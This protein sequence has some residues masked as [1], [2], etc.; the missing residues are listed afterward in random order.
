M[1]TRME[2]YAKYRAEIRRM[3]PEQFAAIKEGASNASEPQDNFSYKPLE[4]SHTDNSPYRLYL[5][6]R[7]RFLW[8]K[9]LALVLVV[10]GFIVWWFLMQGRK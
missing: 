9:I 4:E 2:R 5:A 3:T 10:A 1:E 7:N 8:V 6:H